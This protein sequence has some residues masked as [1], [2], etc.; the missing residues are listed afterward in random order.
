[1]IER[2]N[3]LTSNPEFYNT[4]TSNCTTSLLKDTDLPAWRRYLDWRILLPAYSDRVAYEYGILDQ[5][6]ALKDL[7]AAAYLDPQR[8]TPE[9]AD[10]YGEIRHGYYE[11]LKARASIRR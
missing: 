8:L 3:G 10:F 7:R 4:L 11:R 2:A 9:G 5:S 1:M 6:Y